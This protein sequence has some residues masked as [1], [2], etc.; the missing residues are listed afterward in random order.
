MT[1]TR[2][3]PGLLPNLTPMVDVVF[4]LVVFFMVVSH[5]SRERAVEMTL[6]RLADADSA[7]LGAEARLIVNVVP[8]DSRVALGGA[9]RL[10]DRSFADTADGI[11]SLASVLREARERQPGA[12]VLLR[13][14]RTEP[15]AAVHPAMQAAVLAGIRRVELMVA[16]GAPPRGP[17]P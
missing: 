12:W 6:P 2:R 11:L 16:P 5:L 8:R 14:A 9:Y 10:G 15:Y 4:L 3:S 17:V 1:P 13:A 7:A